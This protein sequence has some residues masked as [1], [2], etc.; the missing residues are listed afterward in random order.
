[1]LMSFHLYCL[2]NS[3]S[4]ISRNEFPSKIIFPETIFPF[5]II[6]IIDKPR[7]LFPHALSPAIPIDWPFS[8]EKLT[9]SNACTFPF[10]VL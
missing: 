2:S 3:E 9:S 5:E 10:D 1:M 4:G 7:V 8:N 6:L